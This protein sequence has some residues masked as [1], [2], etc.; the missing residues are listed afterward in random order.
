[1]A[2]GER[3]VPTNLG[4]F[5]VEKR[6]GY[7]HHAHRPFWID[8]FEF[9]GTTGKRVAIFQLNVKKL[10]GTQCFEGLFGGKSKQYL[11]HLSVFTC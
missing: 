7:H 3:E 9:F 2:A 11:S 8:F 10:G 5:G 6:P 4:P 1:V